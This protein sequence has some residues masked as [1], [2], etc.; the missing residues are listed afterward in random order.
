MHATDEDVSIILSSAHALMASRHT[1]SRL[2]HRAVGGSEKFADLKIG[3][4]FDT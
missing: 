3:D 4:S 1:I 2:S